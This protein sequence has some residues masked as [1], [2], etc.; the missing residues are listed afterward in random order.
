MRH[1]WLLL[2]IGPK[3]ARQKLAP[4]S[5]KGGSMSESRIWGGTVRRMWPQEID[6]FREHLLRL[7]GMKR[8]QSAMSAISGSS[9]RM[10]DLAVCPSGS[11][12]FRLNAQWSQWLSVNGGRPTH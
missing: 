11:L 2:D 4:A 9:S 10:H 5:Q 6:K 12:K 3:R 8:L 1:T 7:F